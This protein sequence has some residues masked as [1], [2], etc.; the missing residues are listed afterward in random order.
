MIVFRWIFDGF[1]EDFL[2]LLADVSLVFGGFLVDRFKV[3]SIGFFRIEYPNNKRIKLY[4]KSN[5]VSGSF[6]S[7][8]SWLAITCV[9]Y[10]RRK[11]H[12]HVKSVL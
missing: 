9:V 3:V 5:F 1:L 4:L 12:I 10:N 7:Q 2:W 8:V 11:P 6:S